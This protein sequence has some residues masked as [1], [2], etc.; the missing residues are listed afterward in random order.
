MGFQFGR[1]HCNFPADTLHMNLPK[2][3]P[4]W[5]PFI[6]MNKH[7]LNSAFPRVEKAPTP[8]AASSTTNGAE[9]VD[10]SSDLSLASPSSY[11]VLFDSAC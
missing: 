10:L 5:A 9:T 7:P 6:P 4:S 1:D 3:I 8:S 11:R 2:L